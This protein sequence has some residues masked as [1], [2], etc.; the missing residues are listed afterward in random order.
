VVSFA[1]PLS[2]TMSHSV[3]D[4]QSP[5]AV[6]RQAPQRPR[7]APRS[8]PRRFSRDEITAAIRAW[9]E[10]YGEP[11]ATADWDPSRARRNG[12]EWRAH[13]FEQGTWPSVEMVR[14]QFGT[15]SAAVEAAGY[16]PRSAPT[17]LRAHVL[18][19]PEIVDAIQE[20]ARRYGSPPTMSDWE[21]SR[22]RRNGHEWRVVRYARG[23]WPSARTV[24]KHF[25]T[26]NAAI[27][28]AGFQPR[29]SGHAPAEIAEQ[30]RA[31]VEVRRTAPDSR[32][33][34][35][36]LTR[37]IRRVAAARSQL[38]PVALRDSLL[39]LAS[40]ALR[41]SDELAEVA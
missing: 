39:D 12:H 9:A 28:A 34:A 16:P 40:A 38:D 29:R 14:R 23:D 8:R 13:R 35:A 1:D 18:G 17:R 41:W 2:A 36:E 26:F 27:E 33:G 5:F 6:G 24:R 25:G 22:A 32:A 19:P 37:Y 10:L 4:L 31:I 21:P 30:H 3:R 15:L 7:E 20:W 11:P